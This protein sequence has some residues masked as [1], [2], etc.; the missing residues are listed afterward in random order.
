[1]KIIKSFFLASLLLASFDLQAQDAPVIERWGTLG[2]AGLSMGFAPEWE[3]VQSPDLLVGTSPDGQV[4][5]LSLGK[6]PLKQFSNFF[7]L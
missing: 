3:V 4:T 2:V 1:M 7:N 6:N 5:I